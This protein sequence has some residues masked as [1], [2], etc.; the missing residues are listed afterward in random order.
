MH[1]LVLVTWLATSTPATL[2][3]DTAAPPADASRTLGEFML[4]SKGGAR[5]EG[6]DG[7]LSASHFT[8]VSKEGLRLDFRP[9]DIEVLYRKDGTQAGAMALYGGGVGLAISGVTT[10]RVALAYPNSFRD[11]NVKLGF[12]AFVGGSTLLGGLIGLAIGAGKDRWS[13]EPLVVPGQQYSLNLS[14]PL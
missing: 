9:E 6:R 8:G 12:V 13:V 5:V 1:P 7:S 4:I 2:S 10:L 3:S 14:H 11:N